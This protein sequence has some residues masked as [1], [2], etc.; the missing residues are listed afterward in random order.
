M[1]KLSDYVSGDF[2]SLDNVVIAPNPFKPDSLNSTITFY[3]LT[4]DAVIKVYTIT[5]RLINTLNAN[6]NKCVWDTR[7]SHGKLLPLGM[8][9]CYITNSRVKKNICN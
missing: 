4:S 7:D 6:I 3:N 5:G 1:D 9:T 8:Y 2:S